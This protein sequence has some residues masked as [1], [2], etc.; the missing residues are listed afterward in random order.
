MYITEPENVCY[1]FNVKC[2]PK[3]ILYFQIYI[4]LCMCVYLSNLYSHPF[5]KHDSEECTMKQSKP[6]KTTI[7]NS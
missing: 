2:F 4:C 5:H 1:E 3:L 7:E 6:S